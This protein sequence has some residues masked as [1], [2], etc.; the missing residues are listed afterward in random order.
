MR[1]A[2][3]VPAAALA[4]LAT[5]CVSERTEAQSLAQRV[6]AAGDGMVELHFAARPGVC[7][8]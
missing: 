3:M 4:L 6:R 1:C 2:T 8:D 7:G 5:A